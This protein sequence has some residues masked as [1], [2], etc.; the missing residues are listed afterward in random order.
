MS[1]F[2]LKRN[3]SNKYRDNIIAMGS[4]ANDNRVVIVFIVTSQIQTLHEWG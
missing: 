1:F 4:F 2:I 3:H